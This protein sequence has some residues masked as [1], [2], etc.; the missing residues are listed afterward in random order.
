MK[1]VTRTKYGSPDI[2]EVKSI[3]KPIPKDNEVL[4]RV[5]A[6]TVNRTDC[7]IV[8]GKP[9]IMRFF[10][11]LF[12]PS[13]LVP[14]TDFAGQIETIGNAVKSFQVGDNVFGFRDEGLQSQA[15][16]MTIAEDGNIA[17]MPSNT[18]Y[19]I[20]AAS[21]EG[22]HYAYN[23]ISKAKVESGQ[24]ILVNGTTGAVGSANATVIKVL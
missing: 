9:F 20:A 24:K 10:V 3:E 23:F 15:E 1:A 7:A 22:A 12:K 16:Y 18:T 13:H 8:T 14:G 5:Y 17:K 4:I 19:E 2:L 11:G 21:L 6:T